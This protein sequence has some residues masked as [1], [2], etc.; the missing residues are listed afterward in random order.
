MAEATCLAKWEQ[1]GLM[2]GQKKLANFVQMLQGQV[3]YNDKCQ[4]RTFPKYYID[5]TIIHENILHNNAQTTDDIP[6]NILNEAQVPIELEDGIPTVEGIPFWERLDGEKL[7]YYKIF[8]EY[9]DMKYTLAGRDTMGYTTRSLAKL[10]ENLN[11]TGTLLMILSKIYHWGLRI[12]AY[13]Y[14]K[15][16][17][18][19]MKKQQV[20]EELENKHSKYSNSLLEQAIEWLKDNPERLDAKTALDM[21]QLGM[22]YGRISVGLLGD[23]PGTS[24]AAGHQ[25]NI[26]IAQSTTNQGYITENV[27]TNTI[28]VTTSEGQG[29]NDIGQRYQNT[30]KRQGTLQ[31]ILHVLNQSGAFNVS[32]PH[33]DVSNNDDSII[34]TTARVME[35]EE[36]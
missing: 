31:S 32:T 15:S 13:D 29:D 22:K 7:E 17:E 20:R 14:Y 8:K 18:I 10:A 28:E 12:K 34:E 3:P 21:V 6:E 9:R 5:P 2:M 35:V 26:Q 30:L 23:K 16:I 33:N 11:T 36:E 27:N 25:T 19:S 24:V 1:G 4:I